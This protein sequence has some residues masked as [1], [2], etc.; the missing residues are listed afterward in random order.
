MQENQVKN[1]INIK[2]NCKILFAYFLL[3]KTMDQFK[4]L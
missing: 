1:I 4:K 2:K 3:T